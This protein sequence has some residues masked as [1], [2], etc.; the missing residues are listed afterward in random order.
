VLADPE[1]R[2]FLTERFC[3][4]GSVDDWIDIGGHAQKLSVVL[5][6][7]IQHLGR[8]SIDELY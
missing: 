4:R 7:S 8:E 2:L 1:K 6:K 3:F 5:K